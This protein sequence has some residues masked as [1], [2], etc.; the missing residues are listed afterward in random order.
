[1][2]HRR[3]GVAERL[4]ASIWGDPDTS[5]SGVDLVSKTVLDAAT[6]KAGQKK[7]AP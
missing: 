1:M 6:A 3:S 7:T 5:N 4:D 2:K